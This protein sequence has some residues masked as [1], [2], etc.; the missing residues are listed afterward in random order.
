MVKQIAGRNAMWSCKSQTIQPGPRPEAWKGHHNPCSSYWWCSPC[1]LP[2]SGRDG[3]SMVYN[4]MRKWFYTPGLYMVKKMLARYCVALSVFFATSFSWSKE[5]ITCIEYDCNDA[6][7]RTLKASGNPH[8]FN[9]SRINF[10]SQGFQEGG[11][12]WQRRG[13]LLDRREYQP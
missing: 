6:H 8:L 4:C 2:S 7:Y 10:A 5:T 11:H 13:I 12:H 9:I 3:D 1:C